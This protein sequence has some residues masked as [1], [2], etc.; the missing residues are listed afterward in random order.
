M[1]GRNRTCSSV[2]LDWPWPRGQ[3]T[4]PVLRPAREGRTSAAPGRRI[5][6]LP[7]DLGVLAVERD[8]LPDHLDDRRRRRLGERLRRLLCLELH[9]PTELHLHQLARAQRVVQRLEERR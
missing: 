8:G 9:L 4:L 7:R 1:N 6:L 5:A 3:R 2:S